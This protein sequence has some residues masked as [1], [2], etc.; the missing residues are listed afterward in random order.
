MYSGE[1]HGV[2]KDPIFVEFLVSE[3]KGYDNLPE[4]IQNNEEPIQVRKI[5]VE[6]KLADF[7]A[8]FKRFEVTLSIAG[9]LDGKEY[10]TP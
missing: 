4:M 1:N 6:M 8:F 3:L 7:F 9:M 2:H 5:E 10:S